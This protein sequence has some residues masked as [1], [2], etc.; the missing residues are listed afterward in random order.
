MKKVIIVLTLMMLFL[1]GCSANQAK[2]YSEYQFTD[3]VWVRDNAHDVETLILHSDGS[4]SY[5][6]ACGNS[7]NDTD[8]CE[9]YTYDDENK[10]I[11]FDYIEQTESSIASIKVIQVS[12]DILELDVDGEIRAFKK[13][14]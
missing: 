4:F 10:E 5:S 3:T 9:G 12:D 8:L 11:K 1:T 13:Q 2:D 7:V 6:C 14:Q